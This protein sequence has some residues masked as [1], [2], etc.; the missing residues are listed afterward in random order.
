MLENDLRVTLNTDDPGIFNLNYLSD[1]YLAAQ[2]HLGL[3]KTEIT[4]LAKNSFAVLWIDRQKSQLPENG[5]AV[6]PCGSI[7]NI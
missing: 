5:G 2:D 3:T 1:V 6:Q 7:A 4:Q